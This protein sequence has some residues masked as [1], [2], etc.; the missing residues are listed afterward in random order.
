MSLIS[1]LETFKIYVFFF[2]L[3]SGDF[4][5]V[6]LNEKAYTQKQQN[7]FQKKLSKQVPDIKTNFFFLH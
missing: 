1:S 2:V 5:V 4:L 3:I 7:N 6:S